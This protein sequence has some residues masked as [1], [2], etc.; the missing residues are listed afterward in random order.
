MSLLNGSKRHKGTEA[1]RHTVNSRA[2]FRNLPKDCRR[3]SIIIWSITSVIG[4]SLC[5][6]VPLCPCPFSNHPQQ[7]QFHIKRSSFAGMGFEPDI[8]LGLFSNAFAHG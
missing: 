7:R 4:C 1:H 5:A 3:W 8:A 2:D 6:S